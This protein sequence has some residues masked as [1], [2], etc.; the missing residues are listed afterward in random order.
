MGYEA[1]LQGAYAGFMPGS[2]AKTMATFLSR[3]SLIKAAGSA[4]SIPIYS[5]DSRI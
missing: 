5:N 4:V 2:A 1:E 3:H